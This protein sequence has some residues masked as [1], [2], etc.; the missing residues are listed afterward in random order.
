MPYPKKADTP[1]K[2]RQFRHV[3]ESVRSRGGSAKSAAMQANAV[4]RDTPARGKGKRG[5]SKK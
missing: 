3:E 1:A 5:R 4:V 2:K